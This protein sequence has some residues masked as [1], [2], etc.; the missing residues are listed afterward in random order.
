MRVRDA[1]MWTFW[2]NGSSLMDNEEKTSVKGKAED[3]FGVDILRSD[4]NFVWDSK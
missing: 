2:S 3:A 4:G 1:Y